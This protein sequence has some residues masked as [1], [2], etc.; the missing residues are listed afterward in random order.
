MSLNARRT[1]AMRYAYDAQDRLT[2]EVDAVGHAT[3]YFRDTNGTFSSRKADSATNQ[4]KNSP[5][6]D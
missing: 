4:V 1:V 2:N 6:S 5:T 3:S